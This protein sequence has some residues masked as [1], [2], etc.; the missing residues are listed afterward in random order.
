MHTISR[1]LGSRQLLWLLFDFLRPHVTGDSTLKTI[2]R[3]CKVGLDRFRYGVEEERLEAFCDKY[4]HVLAG[5]SVD[6]PE[7]QMLCA[8]FYEK[9][10]ELR[11]LE[12]YMQPW[13]QDT[14][15]RNYAYLRNIC[16]NAITVWR[17][18]R[19]QEK[20]YSATRSTSGRCHH[21]APA[22]GSPHRTGSGQRRR[23]H[24]PGWHNSRRSRPYRSRR[25]GAA[26]RVGGRPDAA[27]RGWD[28]GALAGLPRRPRADLLRGLL[29]VVKQTYVLTS[30]MVAAR[31][32]A[33]GSSRTISKGETLHGVPT[34][35]KVP[36]P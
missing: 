35:I 7:D 36:Y 21:A 18:R 25:Q 12:L 33:G 20:M 16:T 26:L 23:S 34:T 8:L 22:H 24:S 6:R 3:S 10:R 2:N 15:V 13:D 14:S 1:R 17:R 32:E 19:N 29:A 27:H 9:V 30:S 4:N 11:C 28:L 5:I 31:G